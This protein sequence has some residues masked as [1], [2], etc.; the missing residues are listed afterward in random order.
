MKLPRTI[1]QRVMEILCLVLLLLQFVLPVALWRL[2]PDPLPTH[3]TMAGEVDGWGSRGTV[4]IMAGFSL[5]LWVLLSLVNWIDPRNWNIPFTI[6]W[7]REVPVYSAVKTM[8]VALKLETM[9]LFAA[10]ELTMALSAGK[11]VL[12]VTGS[13]C[14]LMFVTIAVGLWAAWRQRFR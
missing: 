5:F 13:L 6:P 11:W 1:P 3:Y 10:Q 4:F 7:G 8:L 9:L 14:G 12:P 2:M